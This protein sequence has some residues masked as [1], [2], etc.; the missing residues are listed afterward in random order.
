MGT[1]VADN[2]STARIQIVRIGN[3]ATAQRGEDEKVPHS[4]S[5]QQVMNAQ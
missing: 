3:G 2:Y 4:C 1:L 5:Q